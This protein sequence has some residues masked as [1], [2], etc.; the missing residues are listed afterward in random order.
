ME[1]GMKT[2]DQEILNRLPIILALAGPIC[3]PIAFLIVAL[4]LHSRGAGDWSGIAALYHAGAVILII[5][6]LICPTMIGMCI[7][8]KYS[9]KPIDRSLTVGLAYYGLLITLAFLKMG[10]SEMFRNGFT[11]LG[12][13]TKW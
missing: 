6:L 9:G 12:T 11:I 1:M 8:R 10:P 7:Y 2:E 4:S 13:L 3:W 5:H